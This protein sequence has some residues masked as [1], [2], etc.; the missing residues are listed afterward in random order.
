MVLVGGVAS[1]GGDTG[2]VIAVGSCTGGGWGMQGFATS[3]LR[4]DLVGRYTPSVVLFLTMYDLGSFA[5]LRTVP[6]SQVLVW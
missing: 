1:S 4:C 6:G 5:V 3:G 2:G